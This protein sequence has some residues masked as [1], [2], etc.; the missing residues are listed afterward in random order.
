[1]VVKLDMMKAYDRVSWLFLSKVLK[2]FGFSERI[3]DT[4]FRLV[5]SN[6]YSVLINGKAHGF[7]T[8]LRGV[9]Q[10]Y[11]LSP[12]LFIISAEVL[13]R[14]KES[15]KLMIKK[16]Q[17]YEEVFGQLVNLNKSA[18]YVHHKVFQTMVR[19][20]MGITKIR[21]GSFPFTY[22]GC[23]IYYGRNKIACYDDIIKKIGKRIQSWHGKMLSYG[24]RAVLIS[25]VL[26]SM[27]LHIL[28]AMSPPIGVI[29]HIHRLLARFFWNYK[30]DTRCRHWIKWEAACLPKE[31]SDLGFRLVFDMSNALLC[32]LWG[33]LRTKPFLWASFMINKYCK[34]LHPLI[35]N[36]RGG[37]RALYHVVEENH[38]EEEIEVKQFSSGGEWDLIALREQLSEDIVQH[39]MQNISPPVDTLPLDKTWWMLEQN[40]KFSVK[41]AWNYIRQKDEREDI[42]KYM[43]ERGLP[44][45]LSFFIWRAWNFKLPIDQVL[46]SLGVSMPSKCWCCQEPKEETMSH[47]FLTSLVATK[48]WRM[49]VSCAGINIEGLQLSQVIIK[50]WKHG[51]T[52]VQQ[53]L[54]AIPAVIMWE[55]WKR[56]NKIKHGGNMTISR[57]EYQV[58][59][60]IWQLVR[61]KFSRLAHVPPGWPE[62]LDCLETWR[63][64]LH[65]KKIIWQAPAEGHIKINTYGASRAQEN[66]A[67]SSTPWHLITIIEDIQKFMQLCSV[68]LQHIYREGNKIADYLANMALDTGSKL[69]INGF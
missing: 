59:K 65:Y 37:S 27:P 7:F 10:G 46:H 45:K 29:R 58:H 49:F 39:I 18:F 20:I 15:V 43:W 57:L 42:Y 8:S 62:L 64:I 25:N 22:L 35:A 5:S 66:T 14:K 36:A 2:K 11:P 56:R 26:Q 52:K 16:I 47:L 3:I 1:M 51:P 44:F 21:K 33:N 9:K 41:S 19:R 6:W 4:V 55:I 13:S 17:Q 48:L 38:A 31:E 12:I 69:E 50:C 54:K 23:P 32:K 28:S 68:H 53:L 34:K 40:G 24:G 67:S 63:P 60:T 30:S 61:V